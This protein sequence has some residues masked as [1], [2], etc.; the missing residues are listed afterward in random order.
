MHFDVNIRPAEIPASL[1]GLT[2]ITGAAAWQK[3]END[4][5]RQVHENPLI[6]EYLDSHF[7]VERSMFGVKRY[8][9]NTGRIP[10]IIK[11]P[12]ASTATLYNFAAVLTRV[13]RQLPKSGQD[14]LRKK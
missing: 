6:A 4:F 11:A 1:H 2:E 3:R 5:A 9:Q 12:S 14:A 10:D 8:K 13:F 7:R